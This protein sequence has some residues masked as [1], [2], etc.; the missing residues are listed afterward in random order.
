MN[1]MVIILL[2]LNNN[3]LADKVVAP[4]KMGKRAIFSPKK[5]I[6]AN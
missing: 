2:F 4:K 3:M 1:A 5:S 6:F